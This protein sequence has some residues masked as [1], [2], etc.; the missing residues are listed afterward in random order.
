MTGVTCILNTAAGPGHGPEVREQVARLFAEGGTPAHVVMVQ[1]G[2]VMATQVRHAAARGDLVVAGGGDGTVNAIASALAGTGGVL[3]VLPLGT[4]NHFAKDLSLPLDLAGAVR[5]VL[6]GKV[7]AVDVGEVNGQ[8][9]LNNS[10]LGLYPQ[11]VRSRIAEQKQGHRKWV[12]LAI[13]A[14]SCL[15]HPLSLLVRLQVDGAEALMR[16]TPLLFV[17]NN[18]YDMSGLH[19]GARAQLDGGQLW[20]CLAHDAGSAGLLSLAVRALSGHLRPGELDMLDTADLR[21]GTGRRRVE[22]AWDGECTAMH[23][24]LYY[25]IRPAALRVVVPCLGRQFDARHRPL[26]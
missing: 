11:L 24:P 9:F 6:T 23:A 2:A 17:G 10:S 13:A 22:V 4:C 12:A 26:V 3:G 20:V 8:V 14:V 18:R 25:R 7:R 19:M 5:T 1:A 21:V 15:F 16:R